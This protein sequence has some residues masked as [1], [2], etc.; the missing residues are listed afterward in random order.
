MA[1]TVKLRIDN[2]TLSVFT[3]GKGGRHRT[4]IPHQHLLRWGGAQTLIKV[5]A[6]LHLLYQIRFLPP[7][8]YWHEEKGQGSWVKW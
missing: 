1:I 3:G 6:G 4:V 5:S 7:H 2:S 8:A